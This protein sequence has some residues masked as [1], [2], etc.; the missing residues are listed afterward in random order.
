MRHRNGRV[1]TVR[2]STVVRG[3]IVAVVLVAFGIGIAIGLTV[4]YLQRD[5]T[6][7]SLPPAPTDRLR[8]AL[9]TTVVAAPK[10]KAAT[11][12]PPTALSCGPGSTPRVRPTIIDI[13]CARGAISVTTITW[14]SW[15]NAGGS[16]SGT[17]NVNNCQPTCAAGSVT[18]SPTFVVVS[19]P[20]GGVF[21]D[22]LVTPPSGS[23]TEQSSSQPGSG[24][25]AG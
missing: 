14:S 4:T 20:V 11:T 3:G 23:L 9:A 2:R 25:G 13:G 24:W 8:P 16:G 19:D 12:I 17:L 10:T 5:T 1:I 15:E 18:S 21:Q 22:V 6:R 7:S